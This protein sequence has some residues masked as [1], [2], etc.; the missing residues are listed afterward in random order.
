MSIIRFSYAGLSAVK[1]S[2]TGFAVAV[3]TGNMPG[4]HIIDS[5]V[6]Q[7]YS[8]LVCKYIRKVPRLPAT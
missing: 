3:F 4:L 5:S 8:D 7:G 2:V 1:L 6:T